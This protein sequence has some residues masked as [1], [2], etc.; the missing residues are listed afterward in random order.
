[1]NTMKRTRI[2]LIAIAAMLNVGAVS[3]DKEDDSSGG[4]DGGNTTVEW[5]DL[6]L[7]SGLLWNSCNIGATTPEGY[8]NYYAW[9]ETATKEVYKWSTYRYCNGDYNQLT[10]YCDKSEYGY[11]GF[12]DTLIALEAMDDAA[13][14]ALG[15]GAYMPSKAAWEEL[16]NKTTVK[17]TTM[18]GV[19]DR[20]FTGPNGNTIFLP[21]AGYRWGSELL[22]AG[23]YSYY[24][25]SSLYTGLP[26]YSWYLYFVSDDMGMYYSGRRN[27]GFPI[28]PVRHK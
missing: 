25:S 8:G 6:G 7:P 9:G 28:R 11:N 20:K 12:T 26:I 4:D 24:W 23:N 1:M 21:A 17:W 22:E 19:N 3:C 14:T 16:I 18:N 2:L 13:A 5:V 10:K 15:G 27:D